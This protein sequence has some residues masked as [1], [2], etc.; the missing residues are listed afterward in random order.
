MASRQLKQ[1]VC[2]L[3]LRSP[4]DGGQTEWSKWREIR[5]ILAHPVDQTITASIGYQHIASSSAVGAVFITYVC[6][7]GVI[8]TTIGVQIVIHVEQV[9]AVTAIS[10]ILACSTNNPVITQIAE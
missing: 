8:Q 9:V 4:A 7:S 2:Y 10:V 6:V 1:E 3:R 5:V